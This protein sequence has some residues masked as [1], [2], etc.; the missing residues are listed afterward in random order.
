MKFATKCIQQYPPHHRH[1]AT[2][3]WEIKKFKFSADIQQIR[4]KIQTNYIFS[5]PMNTRLPWYLTDSPVDLRLVLLTQDQIINC[6]TF[7]SVRAL[8]GLPLPSRLST[9]PH[10]SRNF[11]NSLLISR[12]FPAFLTKFICQPLCTPSNTNF[13]SKSCP[14][15]WIPCWIIVDKHSSDVCCDKFPTA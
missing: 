3:P 1:V 5:A 7:S 2:L 10:V 8:C 9:V 13:L 4:K 6:S 11:F 15:C 14:P 12:L